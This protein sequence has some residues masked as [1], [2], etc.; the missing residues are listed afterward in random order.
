MIRGLYTSSGGMQVEML[1]QEAI[2]NN[3]ANVNTAG[4]RRDLAIMEARKGLKISQT[5]VA[6]SADPISTKTHTGV[7]MLGTGVFVN[8]M[9]KDFS[10]G[11]LRE[12][13]S[14]YDLGLQGPGFLT[15]QTDDGK[16][17]YS[18]DG[19]FTRSK[20]GFIVD[21]SGAKLMG[22]KGPIRAD[23]NLQIADDGLV[24]VNGKPRDRL[25]TVDFANPDQDLAKHGDTW[26]QAMGGVG[27][28]PAPKLEVHQGT[29]EG[30]NV[31]TVQEMVAMIACLRQ[32]ESN[33]KA[34]QAQDET[35]ARAVNDIAK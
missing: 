9:V 20:D 24:S 17:F 27:A 30:A 34:V 6:T 31:N 35:L 33:S 18:R 7:G 12:T 32:Y 15:V 10:Q 11:S 4:F 8:R 1:R 25:A 23:G 22:L 13:G 3:L 29:L 16:V 21:K 28:L 19:Q 2:A 5:N 14:P 26:F